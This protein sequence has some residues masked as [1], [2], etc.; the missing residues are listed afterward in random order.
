LP[1]RS[2]NDRLRDD[3]KRSRLCVRGQGTGDRGQGRGERGEG[4]ARSKPAE[5]LVRL[6]ARARR[7]EQR[8][9]VL[10]LG[11]EML[12]DDAVG[13]LIARDLEGLGGERFAAA[14]VG[15]AIEN[16]AHL[17]KRFAADLLILVD[18]I[19]GSARARHAWTFVA[20]ER[21]DTFCHSTHSLPLSLFVRI[22]RAD[23]PA[24]D[25]RFLGVRIAGNELGAPLSPAVAAARAEIV[26][27]VRAVLASA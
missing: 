10:G 3:V 17:V 19:A 2:V 26:G 25:V 4:R 1:R 14:D 18:A 16:S 13:A 7:R 6:L 21:L 9:L 22:W 8:V 11:N 27:I 15:V 20:P 12:G 23:N 24:L 5:R